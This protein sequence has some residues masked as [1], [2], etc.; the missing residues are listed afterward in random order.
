M[1]RRTLPVLATTA[2]L[3]AATLWPVHHGPAGPAR[4]WTAQ[5]AARFWTPERMADSM[6]A[7]DRDRHPPAP[8]TGVAPM[9]PAAARPPAGRPPDGQQP[10]DRPPYRQPPLGRVLDAWPPDGH[11]V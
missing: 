11:P 9:A 1:P 7:A 2:L 6:P 4:A 5:A 10:G 3:A 8:R